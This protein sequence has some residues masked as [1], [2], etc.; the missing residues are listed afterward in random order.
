MYTVGATYQAP[1]VNDALEFKEWPSHG[2]H[3]RPIWH[4]QV[5]LAYEY[6][7]RS[8]VSPEGGE[9]YRE[10][11]EDPVIEVVSVDPNLERVTMSHE[12]RNFERFRYYN[13]APRAFDFIDKRESLVAGN[14]FQTCMHG[15]FHSVLAYCA[16][17]VAPNYKRNVDMK[18]RTFPRDQNPP[19]NFQNNKMRIPQ[20]VSPPNNIAASNKL[21]E[22]YPVASNDMPKCLVIPRKS[23]HFTNLR[24]IQGNI[25][26]EVFNRSSKN[27]LV[28]LKPT[29]PPGKTAEKIAVALKNSSKLNPAKIQDS[30]DTLKFSNLGKLDDT[31]ISDEAL[32]EMSSVYNNLLPNEEAEM[33]SA[34]SFKPPNYPSRP[35]TA[36]VATKIPQSPKDSLME[37]PNC[38]TLS[39]SAFHNPHRLSLNQEIPASSSRFAPSSQAAEIAKILAEYNQ[40]AAKNLNVRNA[41][42]SGA[43]LL[44]VRSTMKTVK[45]IQRAS[46]AS[47]SRNTYFSFVEQPKNMRINRQQ[48]LFESTNFRRSFNVNNRQGAFLSKFS[49]PNSPMT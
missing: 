12:R 46:T 38:P 45:T 27:T 6:N 29:D 30:Q 40:K 36:L 5:G 49:V 4:P 25:L 2:M 39:S 9:S 13:A 47:T 43:N 14:S 37:N 24:N 33:A 31:A 41:T 17:V 35:V 44:N 16:R 26:Q 3:E 18:I 8:Y 32:M 23:I 7:E 48:E 19:S 34:K 28:F 1:S 22:N 20:L 10:I 11:I 42:F 15:S 21:P